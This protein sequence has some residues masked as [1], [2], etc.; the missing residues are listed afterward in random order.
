MSHLIATADRAAKLRFREHEPVHNHPKVRQLNPEGKIQT[1]LLKEEEAQ[2]EP[3]HTHGLQMLIV[4]K[5][6]K[7]HKVIRVR[8]LR[9]KAELTPG[10]AVLHPTTCSQE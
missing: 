4:N 1:F 3:I 7:V 6:Q 9:C 8:A 5:P 2:M 10:P